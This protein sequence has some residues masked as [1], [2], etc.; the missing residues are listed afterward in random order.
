MKGVYY[1]YL[2]ASQRNGTLYV[3]VT[4][5]LIRRV[6]EHREHLVEGFTKRHEVTKLTWFEE[7]HSIYEAIR[8]EKQIKAWKRAWKIEMFRDTNPDWVGL[9]P[10]IMTPSVS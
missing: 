9:Y 8:R 1:V 7:H 10:A 2:L 6:T 5:D 4:N 3:G